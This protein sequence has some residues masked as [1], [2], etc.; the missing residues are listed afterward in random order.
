MAGFGRSNSL[1]INTGNTGGGLL[2]VLWFLMRPIH[3]FLLHQ[4]AVCVVMDT[5][6]ILGTQ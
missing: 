6:W 3:H 4:H 1:S 2:Y 5:M